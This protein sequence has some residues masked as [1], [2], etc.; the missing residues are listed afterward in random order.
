MIKCGLRPVVKNRYV[1]DNSSIKKYGHYMSSFYS[2]KGYGETCWIVGTS[3]NLDIEP[4]LEEGMTPE[5]IAIK[6]VEYLNHR[7]KSKYGR[8]RK[9]KPLYGQFRPQP[10]LVKLLEKDGDKY[11]QVLLITEERKNP[12]FWGEGKVGEFSCRPKKRKT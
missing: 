11:I 5:E 7:P 8:K 1:K 6:C 3:L 4:Y 10:H 12:K 2:V 9:R